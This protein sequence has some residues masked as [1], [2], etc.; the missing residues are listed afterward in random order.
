MEAAVA[1]PPVRTKQGT[2]AL[3]TLFHRAVLIIGKLVLWAHILAA[4]FETEDTA[5]AIVA[6]QERRARY[7]EERLWEGRR[8]GDI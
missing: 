3:L 7:A 6:R 8:R 2:P 1:A 5:L 4:S